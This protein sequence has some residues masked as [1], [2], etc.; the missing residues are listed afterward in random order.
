M[1]LKIKSY[2][3]PILSAAGYKNCE[4]LFIFL[5]AIPD[6][7]FNENAGEEKRSFSVRLQRLIHVIET[8]GN[9]VAETKAMTRPGCMMESLVDDYKLIKKAYARK[10]NQ[11]TEKLALLDGVRTAVIT[12]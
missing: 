8:E 9:V 11:L 1:S 4:E 6:Q 5:S 2:A 10:R 3:A 12:Q 7:W